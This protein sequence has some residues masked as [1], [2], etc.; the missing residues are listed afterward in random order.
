MKNFN[1]DYKK[2]QIIVL[3][4]LLLTLMFLLSACGNRTSRDDPYDRT[5]TLDEMND[6]TQ[7]TVYVKENRQEDLDEYETRFERDRE[8]IQELEERRDALSGEARMRYDQSITSLK[9]QERNAQ[10][11]LNSLKQS[12]QDTWD[13]IETGFQNM[14]NELERMID[15]AEA[16]FDN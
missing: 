2:N 11:M 3:F 4:T 13:D 14:M 10:Q 1:M 5:T 16:E 15:E 8:R 6:T 9:E 7:T 12:S